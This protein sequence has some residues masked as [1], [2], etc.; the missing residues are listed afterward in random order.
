MK[1]LVLAYHSHNI[2][3][4]T[5]AA[6][7]HVALASDLDTLTRR[8]ARI[9]PLSEIAR[10]VVTGIERGPAELVVGISFD[11][12][13][14]FDYA[15]FEHPRF[16]TQRGFLNVLRDFRARNGAAQPTLHATSFVIASPAAR[17]AMERSADCG[18]SYLSEWL[19]ESWWRPAVDSG[20]M[21]IGNHSWDHVHESVEAIVASEAARGNFERVDN[22]ADADREIRAAAQY[23]NKRVG[24]ACELF[25]FPFGHTNDYLVN[26]YLPRRQDRHGMKAAFGT[27]GRAVSPGD[28]VW[29]I[30][31]AVC[32]HHWASPEGLEALL[33]R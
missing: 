31:R 16:G 24:G 29:N 9:A 10:A 25:A 28:P 14:T 5:Y 13:P 6:N 20:L 11:D 22:E 1:A 4:T 27:G 33:P 18:Y 7:D 2:T 32:G 26:D 19:D 21:A 17:N 30:P 23:I 12:G 3:G 15:D 8:G